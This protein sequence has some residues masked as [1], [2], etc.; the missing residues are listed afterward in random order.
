MI[1]IWMTIDAIN[2]LL[3][4]GIDYTFVAG[5]H[6]SMAPRMDRDGIPIEMLSSCALPATEV[7]NTSRRSEIVEMMKTMGQLR[8]VVPRR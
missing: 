3:K 2:D 7:Q 8:P 5:R 4:V 6:I 1:S